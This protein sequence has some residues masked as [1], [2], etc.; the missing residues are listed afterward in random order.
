MAIPACRLGGRRSSAARTLRPTAG[1]GLGRHS[2]ARRRSLATTTELAVVT[3]TL[4]SRT[5]T[6][7][8]FTDYRGPPRA[9]APS[10]AIIVNTRTR[11]FSPGLLSRRSA[12]PFA[13][14]AQSHYQPRRLDCQAWR[15]TTQVA[16]LHLAARFGTAAPAGLPPSA[17]R[18]ASWR[19]QAWGGK[20]PWRQRQR[21]RRRTSV[22]PSRPSLDYAFG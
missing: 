1:G 11:P 19:F 14:A 18:N 22:R 8:V 7:S 3:T 4:E 15:W 2:A 17:R 16:F 12:P 20:F 13:A 6:A 10:Q 5:S 9:P 21:L